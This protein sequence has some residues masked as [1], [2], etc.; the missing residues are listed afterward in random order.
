MILPKVCLGVVGLILVLVVL[1]ATRDPTRQISS[2]LYTAAVRYGY[3]PLSSRLLR[4]NV[5]C[6]YVPSCSHYSIEAVRPG[7]S[8]RLDSAYF[9]LAWPEPLPKP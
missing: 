7:L 1:D 2:Q 6:R 4:G 5:Q 3:Q 9:R 8:Y